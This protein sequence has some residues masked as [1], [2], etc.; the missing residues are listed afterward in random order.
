MAGLRTWRLGNVPD[1]LGDYFQI[2]VEEANAL[3]TKPEFGGVYHP[4]SEDWHEPRDKH[5]SVCIAGAMIG[6]VVNDSEELVVPA[7]FIHP[8]Q[9]KLLALDDVRLGRVQRA[10]SRWTR[11]DPKEEVLEELNKTCGE[12]IA[13][14]GL[15]EWKEVYPTLL[16]RAAHYKAQG[17]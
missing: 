16:Q 12:M 7:E 6:K 2:A 4:F 15:D 11:A 9:K 5:C 8:D 17:V 3:Y 10:I 14:E 1:K 13:W